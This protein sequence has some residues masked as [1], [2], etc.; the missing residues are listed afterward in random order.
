M[1]AG[2]D[3]LEVLLLIQ[4]LPNDRQH[5]FTVVGEGK[6]V[7]AAFKK[8]KSEFLFEGADKLAH[9]G[10]GIIEYLCRMGEALFVCG[11]RKRPVTWIYHGKT[12]SECKNEQNIRVQLMYFLYISIN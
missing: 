8:R 3:L 6:A 5:G 1:Y 9:A 2:Y 11:H 12:K 10:R 4:Y 7:F